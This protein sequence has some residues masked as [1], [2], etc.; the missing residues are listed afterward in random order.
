MALFETRDFRVAQPHPGWMLRFVTMR[1]RKAMK[2][3]RP[4]R[5]RDGRIAAVANNSIAIG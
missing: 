1:F 3:G 2:K 4:T 5:K